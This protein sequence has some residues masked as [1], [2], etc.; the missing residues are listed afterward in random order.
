VPTVTAQQPVV[1][2]FSR[3]PVTRNDNVSDINIS[4]YNSLQMMTNTLNDMHHLLKE[5]ANKQG[6]SLGV[7]L[8]ICIQLFVDNPGNSAALITKF[9]QYS[10]TVNNILSF[11]LPGPTLEVF[12]LCPALPGGDA[13]LE[14]FKIM[15]FVRVEFNSNFVNIE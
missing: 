8:D 7:S 6:M 5:I 11:K 1:T 14:P 13:R 4:L 3:N 9:P 15:V 10:T 2:D 12:L